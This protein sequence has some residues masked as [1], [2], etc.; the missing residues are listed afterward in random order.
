LAAAI[1][2]I[3]ANG[4]AVLTNYGAFLAKQPPTFEVEI[5]EL[6]S[7]SCAHGV[8]RW[9]S[10]CGCRT[11]ADW[12][13]RWRAPLRES[14]D[15]LRGH[16]DA[17]YDPPPP[18]L[19]KSPGEARDAHLDVILARSPDALAPWLARHRRVLRD[20]AAQVETRRLLEMERNR[21]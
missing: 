12:H 13:Q 2:Q 16:I 15:W 7:W 21:L 5:R 11:R 10:D 8:E 18:A 14:L 19:L 4:A 3:E 17:F 1:A 6:T 20:A 9:R